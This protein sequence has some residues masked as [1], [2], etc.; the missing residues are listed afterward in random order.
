MVFDKWKP[1]LMAD[2]YGDEDWTI[3]RGVR[4]S[5][6]REGKLNI[7]ATGT[8]GHDDKYKPISEDELSY[9]YANGESTF[10][11]KYRR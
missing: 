3:E 9:I 10:Y 1:K 4:Y 2:I 8:A 7:V 6:N 11:T 5:Q